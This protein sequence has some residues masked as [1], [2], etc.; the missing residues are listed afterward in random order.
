MSEENQVTRRQFLNYSLMGVGGFLA[1]GM[2]TPMVRFALDPVLKPEK[3]Q[4]MVAVCQVKEITK[5]PKSFT[6][7]VH[8][9][10]GWH[11]SEVTMNAW[12]YLD[13]KDNILS[14]SPICK[15]LGCNVQWNTDPAHPDHFFCPCHYGLYTKDGVNVPN[16]PPQAPLDEYISKVKDGTLYL[17]KAV[18]RKGA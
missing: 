5:E 10:D 12:I 16:T 4:D 7:K 13:E 11:E 8:Q 1:A 9:V 17:G 3:V 14:L 15:H 2:L 18:P 6:F